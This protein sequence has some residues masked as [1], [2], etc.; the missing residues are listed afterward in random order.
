MAKAPIGRVTSS[1]TD[2]EVQRIVA[3]LNA[4]I[5]AIVARLLAAGL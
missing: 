1:S 4:I 5:D 3:Q 2:P